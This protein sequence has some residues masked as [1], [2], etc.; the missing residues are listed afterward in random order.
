MQDFT[1]IFQTLPY[2]WAYN[3]R[4]NIS[5]TAAFSKALKIRRDLSQHVW[6]IGVYVVERRISRR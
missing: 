1:R 3:Y 5:Q 6:R 2:R 4:L